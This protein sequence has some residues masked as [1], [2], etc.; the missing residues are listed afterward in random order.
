MLEVRAW[1]VGTVNV[2]GSDAIGTYV[3]DGKT[4]VAEKC[5]LK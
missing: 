1:D 5:G 4:Y 3:F 2:G